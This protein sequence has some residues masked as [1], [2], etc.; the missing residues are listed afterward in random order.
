MPGSF[1]YP[2]I[3]EILG[4]H[5]LVKRTPSVNPHNRWMSKA[6][7]TSDSAP[8]CPTKK[9]C[10]NCAIRSHPCFEGMP[11]SSLKKSCQ[12]R[13][14]KRSLGIIYTNSST[15]YIKSLYPHLQELKLCKREMKNTLEHGHTHNLDSTRLEKKKQKKT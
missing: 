10:R 1:P 13:R 2:C 3:L 9:Y 5:R 12:S 6:M 11:K 14:V 7:M 8:Q 4:S 15:P